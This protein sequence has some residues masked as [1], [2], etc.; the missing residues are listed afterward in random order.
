[1][2]AIFN[3]TFNRQRN[4]A[5]R[6]SFALVLMACVLALLGAEVFA[7][8]PLASVEYHITG[9]ALQVTPSVLSVPKGIPGSVLVSIVSGGSTNTPASA[10][11]AS[12]AYVQ[13]V[14]RGPGFPTPQRLIGAPNA[15]LMLPPISL[16]G[17][18][19][20][21]S[22]A[23][24][25]SA[26]GATRL[27]GSP[28]SV[29][30]HV[31]DQLLI[32]SVTSRP[33]TADEIQQKG[34]VIDESNFRAIE[35]NVSFVLDGQ[36]IPITFPV[37]SPTFSDSTEIIPEDEV[38]A[39]LQQAATINQQI[40]ST[41]ISLPPDFQTANLNIQLQ[42]INFQVVDP[43]AGQS[44]GLT[45][46]PIPALMVIPGNI[47]YLHQFFSVNIFTENGAPLSSGLSVDNVKATLQLPPGPDG[48]VSTNYDQPGDDPLRFA[49]IG[50]DKIIQSTQQVV[51]PGPDG[52][53]GTGDDVSRL[54]PGE[55]GQA[56]FLVEGLQE[57]L[58][59][60]NLDLTADLYGLVGGVVQVKGKA[61]GSVLVRNPT[62]SL[63]FTHPDTVRVSEPYTASITVL[64]TGVSP[65][66]FVQVTLNKNSISGAILAANQDETI[67]L[68]TILPGQSATAVYHMISQRTGQIRF[69]DLTTGDNSVTGRFNF[70]MGVDAQGVPLSPDTIAMPDY[71]NNLPPDLVEA[72]NRVLGQALSIAT[73]AQLPPNVVPVG[74]SIITRR[75]LDLAEAGQRVQYG[76]PLNR[77]LADLMRDWQ[78]GRQADSGFDSLLRTS[79]AGAQWRSVLFTNMEI[80]DHLDGSQRVADRAADLSGLGQQFVIASAGPGQLRVDFSG[81]TNFATTDFSS[82]PYSMVYAATNGEWAMTPVLTNAV[83]TWTFTNAPSVANM[84]VL[85]VSTNGN[86]RKLTWSVAN[87]PANAVYQFSLGDSSFRLQAD[88]D[89]NGTFDTTLTANSST[90]NELPPTLI[91][92]QQ[93]LSVQAGRPSNPCVGPAYLNYGTVVAVVY[94]KPVTQASAG[95]TN[96]YTVEGDNGANSVQIQPSGRVALLNLRKGVSAIIPRKMIITG[97]TDVRSNLLGTVSVQIQSLTP[98][99]SQPFTGGVAVTGRVL[100]GDGSTVAGVPV[101][102]TMYDQAPTGLDGC[103][104][105]VRRVSQVLTDPNGNFDF[106]F[107]MSGIP[108]SV[109]ATDTSGLSTNA[110]QLILQST[111]TTQPDTQALQ[112]LINASSNP[113]SLLSMLSAGSLPQAVAVVQGLDRALFQDTVNIGSG[114]EGQTEP[115]V[116]R[117]R[118]RGTVTGQVFASDGVTPVPNAAVNLYPDPSSRELGR[119]VFADG[120]GQF[121]FAG[122]PLG[123]FS[124]DVATSDK[125]GATV[126]GIINSPNAVTNITISL[127]DK[128]VSYGTIRGQVYDSDNLTPIGNARI[129]LGHY[130]GGSTIDGVVRIVDADASGA[131]QITN[132]PLQQ[133]DIVAVTFDGLRKGIRTSI[134][135]VGNQTIYENITLQAAT[136]VSGRVQFDDGRPATNALVA[137]GAVLVRSDANGNFQLTGV[138]VGGSVISAGLERN[139]AAGIA[140]PRLGSTTANII[141]GAANYVVVKLRPAGRIFGKVFDAQGNLQP[142]IKVAIPQDGG[143]YWTDAD[144]NGNYFFENLG[145]GNYTVSAP[146][147]QVA[148]QLNTSDLGAQI[149]SGNEDQI[150]AA[151]KEAITVFVGADDPLVNGSGAN[152]HP[153][154]WGYNKAS[155]T[156]DGANVNA[157]IRFIPQGSVSGKVLNGQGIPI[158]AT[159]RLTGLGPD[160]TGAPVMTIR[161]DTTSDPAT[162]LFTFPNVL[163]NGPWALQAASPFYPVILQTNGFTTEI[164]PD[165][166]GIVLRFPPV[167]DVNGRI[168]GHVY[169]ADGTPVGAGAQVHI[170]VSSDY[171]ILTDTNG[172][173]DTQTA[174]PA[175]NTTYAVQVFDPATG[176][177]G[178]AYVAMTPGITNVVDVH[179]LTKNST[180]QVT[181]LQA[182]GSP[183]PGAQVELDQGSYPNDPP[184]FGVTDTNGLATFDGLWEGNYSAMGQFVVASTKLSA[185]AGGTAPPNGLLPL[186]LRLGS[187]GSIV[188]TFVEQNLVTPVVGAQVTVGN[189]GFASTDTNGAFRFDG[190][191]LGT[192]TISS[193]D[194]VTG[195]NAH[196]SVTINFNG[197]T[198]TVQLVEGTLGTVNGFVLNSYNTGYVA[199]ASVQ[200]SFSDGVTPSRTVTT[201]PNGAFSFPGSPMGAF[202]L[203]AQYK[204]P[205]SSVNQVVS[206]NASGT[207]TTLSNVVSVNIQLQ[208]L[209]SL[210]VHVVRNDGSTP[211]Q[212]ARVFAAGFQQDTDANGNVRFNNLTVPGNYG[213]TAISQIGGELHSGAQTNVTLSAFGTNP[214]VTLTLSGIGY[215]TGTVVGSD[216]V[217]PVNN[218]EITLQMQGTIFGGTILT[219][220]SD[221]QG[222]FSFSDVAIGPFLVTA[223]SQSLG[224]SE[225]GIITSANSTNVISLRLGASGTILGR[226]VRADGLTSVGGEDLTIDYMSQSDNAGRAVYHTADDGFFQFNNVPVGAIHV[227]S[228]A[229]DFGGIINFNTALLTNGELLNLGDIPY[230]EDLPSVVQVTPP[231][232]TIDVPIT[233]DVKLLFSEALDTNSVNAGGI[234]IR[235]TN[236][237]VVT[238]TVTIGPDT[239]G[240]R[241]LVK[242]QPTAPLK[243]KQTYQV[244][245]LAGELPGPGNSI[246][247]AGPTDLVGR[248]MA[249][250]FSSHFTTADN[251]PPVLL[252]IFPTNGQAQVDASSVP[253][254]TFNEAIRST[255]FAF[256]LNGPSGSVSGSASVGIN[257]QVLSFVPTALLS[258]NATYTMTISNIFDLAGNRAI[259]DPFIATFATIDTIGPV[260]STLRMVSNA[261]P[262]AGATVMV[263]AL[264]A[265]T[266]PGGSVRFTQDFNPIGSANSNPYRVSV[267]LPGTGSTTIRAIATD[268]YGNDGQVVPLTITV[269]TPQPPTVNYALVSPT[270]TPIPSGS[271]ITVDLIAS[272]DTTI[273]S[274]SGVI[275][276]AATGTLATSNAATI[277]IQG[278]VATNAT[279]NDFVQIFAQATDSL[280]FSSGQK[281]F[282]LPISD[283]TPPG[284]AI[285]S[286][287]NNGHI[288]SGASFNIA[289]FVS[290]NSSNV[291]LNLTI[292]GNLSFTQNVAV[293]LR[294]NVPFTNVFTVPLSNAPVNGGSITATLTAT[295]AATNVSSVV[296]TFWLPNTV[297]PAIS[298]LMIASNLPPI[299]GL[300]VPIQAV[301][302][303]NPANVHVQF[304]RDGTV[305]GTA[306]NAPYQVLVTL[307]ASGSTTIQAVASDEF[308]N[309]GVVAQLVITIQPNIPPSIQFTRV[310]P[311]SGP[312]PSGSSFDVDV[313]ASGNSN[314]FAMTATVGGAAGAN[315][316]SAFGT[317]LHIHGSVPG[318][319]L[320]G[321][322]V[323]ITA[324]AVDGLGQ[325]TGLQP[326]TIPVSDGTAPALSILSPS[327][328]TQLMPGG[329]LPLSSQLSDNS[330][331]V[332]L[333]LVMSG[334]VS[335]TQSLPVA[336][337]PNVAVTNLFNIPLPLV[338]NGTPIVATLTA[339]DAANNTSTATRVFWLPGTNTTVFWN[340]QALGQLQHCTNNSGTYTW[341]NNNN[342]SQSAVFG[343][344]CGTGTPM[345]VQPSNWSTTNYPN[346]T[347]LDVVLSGIGGPTHLDLFVNVH[348]LTIQNDGALDMG[349][350]GPG[351]GLSAVNFFFAGDGTITRSGCCGP[352]LLSLVG[353]TMEKTAG[354]N[355]FAMD[356]NVILNSTNGTLAADVG[357]LAL[358]GNNSF[359]T[360]GGFNVATNATVALVPSGHT[361]NFAGTFT[362]AGSGTVSLNAGTINA[363]AGG[364]T[365]NLPAP[366]F[367]WSSGTVAGYNPLTNAGIME[368][369]GSND[370]RLVGTL[371]NSG[372][373]HHTGSGNLA[374]SQISPG[375][376]FENL[377]SGIYWF[378]SDAG[379]SLV[380][381]CSATAF[382]NYGLVRKSGSTGNSVIQTSFN[383]LGGTISVESGT[384]TLSRGGSST[385]GTFMVSAGAVLDITGGSQPTWSGQMNG[386]GAGTVLLNSGLVY[387]GTN[388]VLNFDNNVFQWAGGTLQGP[389]TNINVLTVSG[390]NPSRLVLDLHNKSLIRHTG[391]NNLNLSQA[392]GGAF[393]QNLPGAT[394]QFENDGGIGLADCCT[395]VVFENDGLL[396][397]VGGTNESRIA[398][399]AF[400]NLGGTIEVQSG[401]LTLASGGSSSNG[402]FVVGANAAVDVTGAQ[403]AAWAGVFTGTGG[404]VVKLTSGNLNSSPS[405]VLNF[406]PGV[407]QWTGGRWSGLT[408]NINTLEISTP[409]LA[410]ASSGTFVNAGLVRHTGEGILGLSQAFGGTAFYNLTNGIYQMESSGGIAPVDCCTAVNFYNFGTFAKL[411]SLSNAVISAAF[412]NL[413][414]LIDVK[415]GTLVLQNN[416][417]SSNGT[418]TVSAGAILDI[419]GGQGP[420]WAG[421]MT[422]RGLGTVSLLGGTLN[423]SPSLTMDF[424]NN[425]FQWTSGTISGAVSN[426][427]VVSFSGT[428]NR[429]IIGRFDNYGLVRHTGVG[430][431]GLSQAAGG[432]LFRNLRG[433]TYQL[434]TN[435][436][437]S[438]FDCC[439]LATFENDGLFRKIGGDGNTTISSA[440]NNLGGT[441]EVDMGQ[442]TLANDSSVNSNGTFNVAAGAVLDLTGTRQPTWSGQMIG[443]GAGQIQ[444]NS[445]L[446]N[447][448]NL[449]VNCATGVF[450]WAGGRFSG[451]ATNAGEMRFSGGSIF[452]AFYNA[453]TIRHLGASALGVSAAGGGAVFH[454]LPGGTYEFQDNG[455]VTP[456][457]CCSSVTFDNA[458]LLRKS[459]GLTTANISTQVFTNRNGSIEVD[460]GTLSVGNNSFAQGTGSFTVRLGGTNVGQ[461]GQFSA[462]S[463]SLG[464]PLS[465]KLTNG[466]VPQIGAQFQILASTSLTGTFSSLD[467]P[468]GIQVNYS[469]SGVFLVVTGQV[470]ISSGIVPVPRPSITIVRSA[471]TATLQWLAD[472]NFI[473]ESTTNLNAPWAPFT[474]VPLT[475]TNGGFN[476]TFPASNSQRYFRLRGK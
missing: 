65:A 86:A 267:K 100:K 135:P 428:D 196:T 424:T 433:A 252:S 335:S 458:G 102:L 146:A 430:T 445:G 152:F 358:P 121:T 270:N 463:V 411:N 282:S 151:F 345:A 43:G 40:A 3:M 450:Q 27:E 108:Y 132:A 58:Q 308:G 155:I 378:N 23:L 318:N 255:N 431:L 415:S 67:Q 11:L 388:A 208:P 383:N 118:G 364:V 396:R 150:L 253:R 380:D 120:A 162:G 90:V 471:N 176:L 82:Q 349:L 116:L 73:A 325:S 99:T 379:L 274:L 53:L 148:P 198:Q 264:L 457:D 254:L 30:V 227:A 268:Q 195:A 269:Q 28:S 382:D 341:P 397:K 202:T 107:V 330:S 77:V 261:P 231:D 410:I 14:I 421:R 212:N 47:G 55:T 217:T 96:S 351:S 427:N 333:R 297:G 178:Q 171:Q 69:S 91:A 271:P 163:L 84:T 101:T 228:A 203:N 400:N 251:D 338:T 123:V 475:V 210:S 26:T 356:A 455:N 474:N 452:G 21:D 156:F 438:Q 72:A 56:E 404:G 68:G 294:P 387:A 406:A 177:K 223:A 59:V 25:D 260:I 393:L 369:S 87:P 281:I 366:L 205:D 182:N 191:P 336:L 419:T 237:A 355:T 233:N 334:A 161:G 346:N 200:I 342:W 164:D 449:T 70:T 423:A 434:E 93:D 141:A 243:S 429:R 106:D 442:L 241:R 149:S 110:L 360:N 158:G 185:R 49:R 363:A 214:V 374:F 399:Q 348:S 323:Q 92:V 381:C 451:I 154:S 18:Y 344:P 194:P 293:A 35:F 367:Q 469:S 46:P 127:P 317:V 199:S 137:G 454:N 186:T 33:L 459:G 225:N 230:D 104:Q 437:I 52:Q 105:W 188:G 246:I 45:I 238:S 218:A 292:G 240:V 37:V 181:V 339:T 347:N 311:I 247:G 36:T 138:P 257:G 170:S 466:F 50:P 258:P 403:N 226:L 221:A 476:T 248:S 131:F 375:A 276:G 160:L 440:F 385:N 143:F 129:F 34:I 395:A 402:T 362:G 392:S 464:G 249:A 266:E 359:Y 470:T 376:H 361:A 420:T 180:V 4:T 63:T 184:I 407:F 220:L 85:I 234:F 256:V 328:N 1:M 278:V 32:S 314:L 239:N 447:A 206:G 224:D 215:V 126:L 124:I 15:P 10:Q 461:W 48:I 81:T 468:T 320:S 391:L 213:I 285:L 133:F 414:G 216:G 165:V 235:G 296:R 51:N 128:V 6:K 357:T 371:N 159:V 79:D 29:P 7:D 291:A 166:S 22:I 144:S 389:F 71:V 236:G 289:T 62:F 315:N 175:V 232:T 172:F 140:F 337:S 425:L 98:G 39:K 473:L 301:V 319:A 83:Y 189:L 394:Y 114:R 8:T 295:D 16:G 244:I 321:S 288:A 250:P 365:F 350:G 169:Y 465:V 174:F 24:I 157:D 290:D 197:Q 109:S 9:T 117:F 204:L 277:R 372:L 312:I 353:G 5:R 280:G 439:S 57:G 390:G 398:I 272:G 409:T 167:T 326:L 179:L 401:Q 112:Q 130:G 332:T 435:S 122:V 193:S 352:T 299:G 329:T 111:V 38:L 432:A 426:V 78:G 242:V 322:Q 119:G 187:T 446:I 418:I 313:I 211:A 44:L 416:G 448:N 173:F 2:A 298:Q 31:F 134:T 462:G 354:T 139:P 283:A 94:S 201:G 74:N 66:N 316:F 284:I 408:T 54:Q 413:G 183:A 444:F 190:M 113:N 386:T 222:K 125:R 20:L 17:D 75:V 309:V 443:T 19:Q 368:L 89:G 327:E 307:P 412:N 64:N 306:T 436:A 370:G 265:T 460:S 61:A 245:V 209:T 422:G 472:S 441:V 417:S 377:A 343:D 273:D 259:G 88:T 207:L 310:T 373:F 97:V 41:M 60:M 13:A 80:A 42:G 115:V 168:V 340:R 147:N 279:V 142:G 286:P 76:D 405:V 95:L 467:I 331:G 219:A 453:G 192:Y 103:S 304:T 324:Q 153:S 305:I 384:I 145:L 12:G 287:T 136:T 263:E 262:T 303:G 229:P 302:A 275:G 456:V 300:T